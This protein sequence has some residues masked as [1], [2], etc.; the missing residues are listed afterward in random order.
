MALAGTG[1]ILLTPDLEANMAMWRQKNHLFFPLMATRE[2]EPVFEEN[3]T[4]GS[5]RVKRPFYT[6]AK[7]GRTLPDSDLDGM[8]DIYTEIKVD[9]WWRYGLKFHAEESTLSL[10][11]LEARYFDS[12]KEELAYMYDISC[13]A[14]LANLAYV[15]FANVGNALKVADV[16]S[17]TAHAEEISIP[18]MDRSY[19]VVHPRDI[20]GISAELSKLNSPELVNSVIRKYFMGMLGCWEF[21]Q[22]T[23]LPYMEVQSAQGTPL[24]RG[25]NQR[26][27]SIETDGWTNSVKVLNKGQVIY[28]GSTSAAT[29]AAA[30]VFETEIRGERKDLGNIMTFTVTEDVMSNGSGQ[31]TIHISP[32][33]NDGANVMQDG[34]GNNVT[35][36]GFKNCTNPPPDN[37]QI[38]IVGD[39][40][41][42][43]RQAAFF[44]YGALHLVNVVV[45]QPKEF[46][47]RGQA[48]DPETGMSISVVGDA[49]FSSLTSKRRCDALFGTKLLRPELGIRQI[50]TAIR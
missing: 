18:M 6:I 1:N 35:L 14:E 11:D 3:I 9:Q 33:L 39:A 36:K 41:K 31:A 21:Y 34:D 13:G 24:V 2:H 4:G 8:I 22:T 50:T 7:K 44:D 23:H 37:A 42:N 5:I 27:S 49:V 28:F 19:A 29:R 15:D 30:S 17:V 46:S 48:T 16:W 26:G 43:Y 32:D 20:P 45:K 38:G 40:G 12:G 10:K 25:A 47:W